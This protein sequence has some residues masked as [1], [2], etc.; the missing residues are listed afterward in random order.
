MVLV[1]PLAGVTVAGLKVQVRPVTGE[2]ENVTLFV[3]PPVGVTVS[4]NCV[5]PPVGTVA[6]EGMAAN[7]KSA[8]A[9]VIVTAA[10]VLAA[11]VSSPA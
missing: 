11:N 4:M 1:A 3:N 7:K 8:A 5:E 6:L 2:Q 10:E 9:I